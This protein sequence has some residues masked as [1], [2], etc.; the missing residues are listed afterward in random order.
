MER[1]R[2]L[3]ALNF[4]LAGA[5]EGFGAFIAVYL[6]AQHFD[7]AATGI[8]MALAGVGGLMFTAPIGA[9]IDRSHR[10]RELLMLAVIAIALAALVIIWSKDIKV[11]GAAQFVIGV[12]DTALAPLLA[13]MTLG[14]VGLGSYAG[15]MSRN[16]AFNHAGSAVRSA[17]AAGIGFFFGLQYVAVTIVLSSLATI[18]VTKSIKPEAIDHVAA[19]CGES[20]GES[21]WRALFRMKNLVLLGVIVLIYQVASSAMLPFL[22]EARTAAGDDPS[23]A[24]GGMCVIARFATVPAALLAPVI[25]RYRGYEGVMTLVLVLVVLRA[26]LAAVADS[27]AVVVPVEVLEGMAVGMACV[28]IPALCAEIMDGTGRAT[29][30]LGALLT[31]FGAGATLS[32]LVGGFAAQY[33]GF[34]GSFIAYAII[35]GGG[36]IIWLVGRRALA[37]EFKPIKLFSEEKALSTGPQTAVAG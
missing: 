21:T 31:A 2:T 23:L 24:T 37:G 27:W 36:L 13:A 16:E 3:D 14:M 22:A 6:Q 28:A 25:A 35:A 33:F 7:P 32:P 1:N 30:A 18:L 8:V 9:V 29:V 10:K 12:G 34:D 17:L 26:C 15:R 4:V 19:R 5:R 11:V 20:D